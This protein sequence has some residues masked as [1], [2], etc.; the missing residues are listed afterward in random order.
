MSAVNNGYRIATVILGVI[1][2]LFSLY[3]LQSQT[4][5]QTEKKQIEKLQKDVEILKTEAEQQYQL[6]D[7]N[8][9]EAL[10]LDSIAMAATRLLEECKNSGRKK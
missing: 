6:A 9:R 4:E 5:L 8:Q 1:T 7:R 2:I 3:A 10:R